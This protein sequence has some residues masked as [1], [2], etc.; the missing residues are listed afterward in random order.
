MTLH[1]C[2]SGVDLTSGAGYDVYIDDHDPES[3]LVTAGSTVGDGCSIS[4]T[5]FFSH[6]SYTLQSASSG[7]QELMPATHGAACIYGE[8]G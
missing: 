1:P 5:P 6:S 4:F 7:I 2:P 3:V 8:L